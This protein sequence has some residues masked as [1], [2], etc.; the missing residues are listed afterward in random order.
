MASGSV[1]CLSAEKCAQRKLN[2]IPFNVLEGLDERPYLK[3]MKS[4]KLEELRF[5][6]F[7]GCDSFS[8]ESTELLVLTDEARA[9]EVEDKIEWLKE[10]AKEKSIP[11]DG[12]VITY[13]D[14][15]YAKSCGA[16][17]HHYKDGIAFK[18]EDDLYDTVLRTVEWNPTRFGEIAPVAIFD[19]VEIDGCMVSRATL[20]NLTFIEDLQLNI[21]DRIL[22]SKRNMIIPQV[23]DNLD[24]ETGRMDYPSVCPC[25]GTA[26]E[27][28]TGSNGTTKTLH[29]PNAECGDKDIRRFIHFVSRKAMNI[30]GL[31]ESALTRF[32]EKGWLKTYADIY[33]LD[34]YRE[35]IIQMD[36]FGEKSY[37]RM[38]GAIQNS[39]STTFERFLI[40]MDIP[41][42]GRTA[43]RILSGQFNGDI[44]AFIKAVD[45]SFLFTDLEGFG[46]TLHDNI[47]QWFRIPENRE[48]LNLMKAEV[49]FTMNNQTNPETNNTNPFAGKTVV[50][51]GKLVRGT[52]EEL[53]AKLFSLGAKP[54]GAVSSGTDFLIVGEK[55]GSKLAKAQ[56]LGVKTLTEAEFEAM[57]AESGV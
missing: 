27:I 15:E 21:G 44:D 10:T 23:E 20:H 47:H 5:F 30:E 7:S 54:S 35:E 1:R 29:C 53:Q 41:L 38:W 34:D 50:I 45:E 22:I 4:A 48:I 3:A 19:P 11:I 56:S 46:I 17:G 12:I 26:T 40:G 55:A 39:R 57:L 32:I 18:F 28:I 33:H 16:T 24:R 36:G 37:E 42:I 8:Y 13:D 2:F 51:T 9:K 31:S 14:I 6:G 49:S 43:S 25:C 52:R